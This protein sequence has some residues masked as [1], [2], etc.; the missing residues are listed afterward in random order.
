MISFNKE[1]TALENREEHVPFRLS[2]SIK[3]FISDIGVKSLLPGVMTVACMATKSKEI[4]VKSFLNLFF[5]EDTQWAR[6]S[7][8]LKEDVLKRLYSIAKS[9]FDKNVSQISFWVEKEEERKEIEE[10]IKDAQKKL[11]ELRFNEAAH[12]LIKDAQD[13]KKLHEMHPLFISWF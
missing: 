8:E 6:T 12:D 11:D 9:Y 13:P 5:E 7:H 4:Y 10:S 1:K 3:E 2:D